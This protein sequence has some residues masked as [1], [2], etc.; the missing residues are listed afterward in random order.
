VSGN[1]AL[2]LETAVAKNF[3]A[4]HLFP[5]SI[6]AQIVVSLIALGELFAAFE[7]SLAKSADFKL[8][9]ETTAHLFRRSNYHSG[10][11]F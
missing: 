8:G 5:D 6:T 9:K 10:K 2:A 1:W 7:N 3:S 11:S 4:Q